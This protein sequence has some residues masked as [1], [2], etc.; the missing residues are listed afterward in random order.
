MQAP[1]RIVLV[2]IVLGVTHLRYQRYLIDGLRAAVC[3]SVRLQMI[4]PVDAVT[5]W[6]VGVAA[7]APTV[8]TVPPPPPWNPP[9]L[10]T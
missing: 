1:A 10:A 8:E 2:I 9:V 4:D 3:V 5:T 6:I 7:V